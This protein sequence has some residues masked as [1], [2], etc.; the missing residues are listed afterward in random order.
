MVQQS[1]SGK[2]TVEPTGNHESSKKMKKKKQIQL[3]A[4]LKKMFDDF[5]VGKTFSYVRHELWQIYNNQTEERP[6][7]C[8]FLSCILDSSFISLEFGQHNLPTVLFGKEGHFYPI[9]VVETVSRLCPNLQDISFTITTPQLPKSAEALW[10][11]SFANLKCLIKLKID[12][13]TPSSCIP[14]FTHLGTS[15]S[16]LKQLKI[17]TLPFRLEQQLALVLGMKAKLIPLLIKEM[18]LDKDGSCLPCLQFA[19]ESVVPICRSLEHLSAKFKRDDNNDS[20]ERTMYRYLNGFLLRNFPWLQELAIDDGISKYST[21][22][23]LGRFGLV[24]VY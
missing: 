7:L 15:C 1:R 16:N 20:K 19:D 24:T 6:D 11:R 12:W 5:L 9:E 13:T 14:F 2:W 22:L 18:M 17:R 4:N 3:V 8:Q 21:T 23:C 10:S